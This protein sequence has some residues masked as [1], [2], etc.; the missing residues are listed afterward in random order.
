M[1][2]E[3]KVVSDLLLFGTN[4]TIVERGFKKKGSMYLF[5]MSTEEFGNLIPFFHVHN[6]IELGTLIARWLYRKA[7]GD[8]Q[9]RIEL[10]RSIPLLL[11]TLANDFEKLP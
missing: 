10:K 9:Y 4:A 8:E 3:D 11:R 6:V 5:R 2:N 1:R 7:E